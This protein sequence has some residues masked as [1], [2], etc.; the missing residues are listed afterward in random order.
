M[1]EDENK[2]TSQTGR[3]KFH[4]FKIFLLFTC[5]LILLF[6][7]KVVLV[8]TAKPTIKVDYV[9]ELNRISK[10]ADYDPNDNAAPF[11]EKAFELAVEMPPDI[12]TAD[13]RIWPENLD[14]DKRTQIIDWLNSNTQALQYVERGSQKLYY[15]KEYK[16][17]NISAIYRPELNKARQL[18]YTI[19]SRVLLNASEGNFEQSFSD[20][21]T[22][23]RFGMHFRGKKTILEQLVGITLCAFDTK[24]AFIVLD[25]SE[26]EIDC[27][28]DFQNELL[29]IY[30]KTD[31]A[32]DFT[33]GKLFLYDAI[34]RSFTD[35]GKGG[36]YIPRTAI[37]QMLNPP[38]EFEWIFSNKEN[39][40]KWK[41]IER[42]QTTKL[43]DEIFDYINT[44]KN[45]TP[46]QLNTEGENITD[47]LNEMTKENAYVHALLFNAGRTIEISYRLK[48]DARALLTTLAILRYK[49]ERGYLPENLEQLVENG[50]L[51]ELPFDPLND[52]PLVYKISED[53]FL[54]YSFG[55]DF[56]DDGGVPSRWGEGEDGGD[57][58]FWPVSSE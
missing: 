26:P 1:A 44:A 18:T 8:F 6:I 17:A 21:I 19:C 16:A 35:D 40:R 55:F 11:Y 45:K 36:G 4:P 34:Q 42:S 23:Y 57:Q 39:I 53:N 13:L 28:L 43:V 3:K 33:E 50:Y 7:L 47:V 56:D 31:F 41:N 58:V 32:L 37:R 52:K 51:E 30:S 2:K 25:N 9:A 49:T 24:T 20:I 46:Y 14:E 15:Y 22:C 54:L 38:K 5:I 48:T 27:L 29:N 10:P 12:N